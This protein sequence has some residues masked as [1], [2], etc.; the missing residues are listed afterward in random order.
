MDVDLHAIPDDP[1]GHQLAGPRTRAELD[2]WMAAHW[3]NWRLEVLRAL[4][5]GNL[6]I[7]RE[8]GDAG[9]V[10]A[11]CAFEVNRRGLLGPV[12]VRP[13]LMGKGR[14]KGVLLGA[15]H[16]L[17]RRGAR[18]RVRRLGRTGGALCGRGRPGE[19]RVLRL[20]QGAG[21][22]LL[23][24]PRTLE[25]T[26][27][28]VPDRPPGDGSTGRCPPGLRAAHRP[29]GV[30]LVAADDA[31]LFYGGATLAQLARIHDGSLPA[32][33]VARPSRSAGARRH[34]RHLPRQGPDHGQPAE[35]DRPLASLKVNQVQLYS[36][37]TFA[38]RDHPTV[39]AE[40]SPLDAEEIRQLD[41]F[42]RARHVELVPNQN[43][44]GHMNRWLA[45]EPYRP[46]AIA[47]DGFVD[48]YGITGPP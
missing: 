7:A 40:A 2:E 19:R 11:F 6:V 4:D 9:P 18:A 27:E 28:V 32:G 23:P 37:H 13:E 21:V 29:A 1:G 26:D 3:S 30:E 25:L 42:C 14:G 44:L 22:N 39:H 5:K 35:R 16:E 48:P 24:V 33:L 34:A 47:P 8:D 10:T 15:L 12:A 31:G 45:H 17:R 38:Y 41:A 36:E 46:L 43:C 20:P